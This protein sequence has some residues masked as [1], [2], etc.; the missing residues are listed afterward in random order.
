MNTAADNNRLGGLAPTLPRTE[1]LRRTLD[2]LRAAA[3]S[4]L[5]IHAH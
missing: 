5:G 3:L 4:L 1:R 2:A